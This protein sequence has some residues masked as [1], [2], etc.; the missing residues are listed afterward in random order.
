MTEEK[1]QRGTFRRCYSN[2]VTQ[3]R[4]K[5]MHR[6]AA[7]KISKSQEKI[8]LLIYLDDIQVFAKEE[9]ELETLK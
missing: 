3:R 7:R 5:E 9:I 1:I 4:T 2:D 6:S 8:N